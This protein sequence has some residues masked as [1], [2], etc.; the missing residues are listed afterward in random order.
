MRLLCGK[1]GSERLL[2]NLKQALQRENQEWKPTDYKVIKSTNEEMGAH[3]RDEIVLWLFKLNSVCKLNP[4]TFALSISILDHFLR[5]VKARP[6]YM[7]CIAISCYFL[8]AKCLEEDEVIPTTLELVQSSGCGCSVAEVLR[9]EKAIL[10]KLNWE[11]LRKTSV[12]FLHLF[13]MLLLLDQPQLLSSSLS[14]SQQ[15][16]TLTWQLL[17]CL[18]DHQVAKFRPSAVALSL[19]SIELSRYTRDWL[20]AT[21]MLQK[22]TE[23][24]SMDL[25]RCREVISRILA[26]HR[27]GQAEHGYKRLVPSGFARGPCMKAAKRK[28]EHAEAD[29]DIY[30][31]IKR[32]YGDESWLEAKGSCAAQAFLEGPVLAVPTQNA[33]IV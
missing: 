7:H 9:M 5:V 31:S 30:D 25:I 22:L 17:V 24:E 29:D 19:I 18:C 1:M 21:I 11:L 27:I 2:Q 20:A 14:A 13:H 23:L 10:D 6:K 15:L 4:E 12:D 33:A 32:L 16:S 28:V 8:A 3:Q 26:R